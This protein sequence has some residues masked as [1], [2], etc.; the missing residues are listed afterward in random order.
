MSRRLSVFF[1]FIQK[2][3]KFYNLLKVMELWNGMDN[4][5]CFVWKKKIKLK[6][7]GGIV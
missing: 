4:T 6:N 3:N 2:W 1:I 5:P 7:L